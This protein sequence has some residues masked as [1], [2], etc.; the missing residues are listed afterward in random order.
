MSAGEIGCLLGI[1]VILVWV[2]VMCFCWGAADRAL[3]RAAPRRQRRSSNGDP[4]PA[5]YPCGPDRFSTAPD[6]AGLPTVFAFDN[7]DG[8]GD[9]HDGTAIAEDGHGLAGHISS[10]YEFSRADMGRPDGERSPAWPSDI[11][12]T[13]HDLYRAHYPGGY[14]FEWVRRGE[15]RTH[16]GLLAAYARNQALSE[17]AAAI[18]DTPCAPT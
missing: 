13:K 6:P 7:T 11:G 10:S 1:A 9:W 4:M 8:V 3:A 15:V 5:L 17:V 14:V 12:E 2:G 18:P 16:A